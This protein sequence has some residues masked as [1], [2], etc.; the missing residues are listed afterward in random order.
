AV[1][2]LRPILVPATTPSEPFAPVRPRASLGIVETCVVLGALDALF[3]AFVAVQFRS[4]FGG[5]AFVE[6]TTGLTY[7]AYARRGFFELVVVA[8]LALPL[9]VGAD[10]LVRRESRRDVILFRALAGL[11]V[12]L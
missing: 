10:W 11:L 6:R 12:L 2:G 1:G 7:A 8:A 3:A 5:A 4:A 9:L